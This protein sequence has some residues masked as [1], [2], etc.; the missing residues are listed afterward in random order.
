MELIVYFRSPQS[1]KQVY[2]DQAKRLKD[3][4]NSM[5]PDYVYRRRPNDVRKGRKNDAGPLLMTDPEDLSGYDPSPI[6]GDGLDGRHPSHYSFNGQNS[7][8]SPASLDEMFPH[9]NSSALHSSYPYPQSHH[10]LDS[11]Y[12]HR[13]SLQSLPFP[14]GSSNSHLPPLT[15][16]PIYSPH[17]QPSPPQSHISGN[18]YRPSQPSH[19]GYRKDRTDWFGYPSTSLTKMATHA[20]SSHWA[21]SMLPPIPSH[22]T[23]HSGTKERLDTT[24]A[25]PTVE[26]PLRPHGAQLP[27]PPL[28]SVGNENSSGGGGGVP[29][30]PSYSQS[31]GAGGGWW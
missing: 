20:S 24:T 31:G 15:S 9:V 8:L 29:T 10:P 12:P 6:D 19:S 7:E 17:K 1:Q 22:F 26:L 30:P 28:N 18:G 21:S 4:F 13:P 23:S 2:L 11:G 16:A 3:I 25:L 14:H 5:Y 27:L